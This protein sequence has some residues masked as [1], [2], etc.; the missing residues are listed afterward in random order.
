MYRIYLVSQVQV[1]TVHQ[2]SLL[3]LILWIPWPQPHQTARIFPANSS[4]FERL[5]GCGRFYV[6]FTSLIRWWIITQVISTE[7]S[8]SHHHLFHRTHLMRCLPILIYETYL[9]LSTSLLWVFQPSA[10]YAQD[11]TPYH[12]LSISASCTCLSQTKCT[13]LWDSSYPTLTASPSTKGLW[14]RYRPIFYLF[15]H[16]ILWAPLGCDEWLPCNSMK[17]WQAASLRLKENSQIHIPRFIF[18][19]VEILFC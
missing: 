18:G 15:L 6:W 12:Q 13:I 11:Y 10:H 8:S 2:F 19:L 16:H 3:S 9:L 5:A 14:Y 7:Q 1:V 4:I 17:T